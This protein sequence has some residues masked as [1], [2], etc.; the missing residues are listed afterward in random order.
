MYSVRREIWF[1]YERQQSLAD[2]VMA[3]K[4]GWRRECG[5][6]QSTSIN[7]Y[8]QIENRHVLSIH[9]SVPMLLLGQPM[10]VD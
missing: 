10:G 3:R 9:K 7:V 4:S 5:I 6:L 8:A 2:T 1:E